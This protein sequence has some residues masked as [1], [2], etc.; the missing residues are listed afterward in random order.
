MCVAYDFNFRGLQLFFFFFNVKM[1]IIYTVIKS[2]RNLS[3]NPKLHKYP[4]MYTGNIQIMFK[5]EA[6]NWML[7]IFGNRLALRGC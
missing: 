5:E 1:S 2:V 6:S 7:L 4:Q 3:C